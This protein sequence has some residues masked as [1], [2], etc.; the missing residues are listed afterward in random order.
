MLIVIHIEVKIKSSPLNVAINTDK[1]T[2]G[3]WKDWLRISYSFTLLDKSY[4]D[5]DDIIYFLHQKQYLSEGNIK[6]VFNDGGLSY[7]NN[8]KKRNVIHFALGPIMWKL[9]WNRRMLAK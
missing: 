4:A 2:N 8:F 1:Q 7:D 9:V 3:K 5:V 6:L